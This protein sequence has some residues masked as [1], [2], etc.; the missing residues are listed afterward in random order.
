[1]D[2]RRSSQNSYPKRSLRM[3]PRDVV[4]SRGTRAYASRL[5]LFCQRKE[6]LGVVADPSDY[7]QIKQ[8]T[9]EKLDDT[10]IKKRNGLVG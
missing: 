2:P 4:S 8:I 7:S 10:N 3:I 1:M 9:A 6:R 5:C